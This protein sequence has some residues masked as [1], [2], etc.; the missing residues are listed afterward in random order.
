MGLKIKIMKRSTV[1]EWLTLLL[2]T[3]EVPGSNLSLE[4]GYPDLRFCG[5]SQSLQVNAGIVP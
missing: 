3:W 2:H 5:F 1:V 4:T